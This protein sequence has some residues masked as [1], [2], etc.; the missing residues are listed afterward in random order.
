MRRRAALILRAIVFENQPLPK[1]PKALSAMLVHGN[2]SPRRS[3]LE[4][5]YPGVL[6]VEINTYTSSHKQRY[7]VPRYS[8]VVTVARWAKAARSKLV[9]DVT[10][11]DFMTDAVFL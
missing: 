10:F 1:S 7:W 2:R 4:I 3:V 11:V 8:Y 5:R 6:R 9:R